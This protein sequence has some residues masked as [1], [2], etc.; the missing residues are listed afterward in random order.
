MNGLSVARVGVVLA[1]VLSLPCVMLAAKLPKDATVLDGDTYFYSWP[2]PSISPDGRWV[3]YISQGYVCVCNVNAP[4]RR[5]IVEVP[6]SW[7]W[8]NFVVGMGESQTSGTFESLCHGQDREAYRKLLSQV[9]KTIHGL[10]WKYDSKGF[11]FGIQDQEERA[12]DGYFT[13]V[14]G[15]VTK[16]AHV[17]ANTKTRTAIVGTLSRDERFL[18]SPGSMQNQG[19]YRPIIWNIAENKPRAT[20]FLYLVPSASSD[21]WLGLEKDSQQLVIANKDFEVEQRFNETRAEKTFGFEL[22]WSPDERFVIWRNQVGF[23]YFSNWEGFW[24]DLKT[25]QKKNLVG[26]FMD[27]Q[28][29]FTGRGGEFIRCGQDGVRSKHVSGSKVTGAHLTIDPGGK[30]RPNDIWR[31][32]VDEPDRNPG[33]IIHLAGGGPLR[34][35]TD[36]NLFA[37]ALPKIDG[38]RVQG[39][40]HLMDR[41]GRTW[42]F[43]GAD[44][45]KYIYPY[46]LVGFADNGQKIIAYD[47]SR[48]FS[49]PIS[50]IM[51][52]ANLIKR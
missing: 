27:E 15:T 18:V 39:H 13:T 12:S 22:K 36:T 50:S 26:H 41:A 30:G 19:I 25:G 47:Y 21:R 38:S 9:T 45:G 20:C 7:T 17:D 5:R 4:E 49:I 33:L 37:V 32:T 1:F 28:I 43:P 48:L 2:Y 24:L 10:V 3:A 31:I 29:F 52:D 16:I 8:P 14:N 44:S 46:E 6:N 35:T 40:W 42:K 11:V 51:D 34:A 23:D